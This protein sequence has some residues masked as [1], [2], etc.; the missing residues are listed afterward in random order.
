MMIILRYGR[1]VHRA[2]HPAITGRRS[3]LPWVL[4]VR[5]L[6]FQVVQCV[7]VVNELIYGYTDWRGS[8]DHK[9]TNLK[10]GNPAS[11]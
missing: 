6:V 4:M 5:S 1:D 7:F 9:S 10:W 11:F 2:L 8:V 3:N